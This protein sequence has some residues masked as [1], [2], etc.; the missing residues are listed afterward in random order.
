MTTDFH[1]TGESQQLKRAYALEVEGKFNVVL[2]DGFK[3]LFFKRWMGETLSP[4]LYLALKLYSS[5][6]ETDMLFYA[7]IG[8]DDPMQTIASVGHRHGTRLV[9]ILNEGLLFPKGLVTRSVSWEFH[10]VVCTQD[11]IVLGAIE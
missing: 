2:G 9:T 4:D 1:T 10:Q 5:L 8:T 3:E 6:T 7:P 11:G